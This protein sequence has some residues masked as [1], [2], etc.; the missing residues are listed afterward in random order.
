MRANTLRQA[1][2]FLV[3]VAVHDAALRER[4]KAARQRRMIMSEEQRPVGH[5]VIDVPLPAIVECV[6]PGAARLNERRAADSPARADRRIASAGEHLV[7]VHARLHPACARRGRKRAR[8]VS[9]RGRVARKCEFRA[10]ECKARA[11]QSG[12]KLHGLH[13]APVDF[14]CYQKNRARMRGLQPIAMHERPRSDRFVR[15]TFGGYASAARNDLFF[16]LAMLRRVGE[17]QTR[18]NV[19]Q[20]RH[21]GIECPA[22]RGAVNP[23][24][25]AADHRAS[26]TACNLARQLKCRRGGVPAAYDGDAALGQG[27]ADA[28]KG[29]RIRQVEQ[30]RRIVG[31]YDAHDARAQAMDALGGFLGAVP[32]VRD[33]L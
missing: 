20:R 7:K 3:R 6:G 21:A 14:A 4:I 13:R 1:Y 9:H 10:G 5:N 32:R 24:G 8:T 11:V 31:V 29:R 28:Q 19:C 16:Q 18:S 33:F 15:Q 26:A 2:L 25:K 12:G 27:P 30:A 17:P 22:V 23:A